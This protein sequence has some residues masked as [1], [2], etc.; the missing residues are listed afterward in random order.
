MFFG[1]IPDKLGNLS[2]L[3]E[4]IAGYNQFSDKI[5][6]SIMFCKR[7]AILGLAEN[8]L[9]GNIPKEIFE[10]SDLLDL[11]LARNFISGSLPIE[12][13][14]LK[15]VRF[16]DISNNQ[17]A[18]IPST[19]GDCLSLRNLS[20]AGNKFNSSIP[21][22]I[23]ASWISANEAEGR[24][25]KNTSAKSW[26]NNLIGE[27]FW[28]NNRDT[29]LQISLD[30]VLDT[31]LRE[32]KELIMKLELDIVT[33]VQ[34]Y[35]DPGVAIITLAMDSRTTANLSGTTPGETAE[36]RDKI[37]PIFLVLC[38]RL[39]CHNHPMWTQILLRVYIPVDFNLAENGMSLLSVLDSNNYLFQ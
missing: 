38:R 39:K 25:R 26:S 24:A 9:D 13:N 16:L 19:I 12:V 5:P 20:M 32:S 31:L 22:S 34:N 3:Y 11:R 18:G 36:G 14:K 21:K 1:D 7:L 4:I 27:E 35:T 17:L 23:G 33:T 29:F 6:K 30:A 2:K 10:L 15:Q 28:V 37:C 8:R